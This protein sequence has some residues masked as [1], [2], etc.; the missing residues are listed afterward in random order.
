MTENKNFKKIIFWI[1]FVCFLLVEATLY[2]L[3][4]TKAEYQMPFDVR[5]A[6]IIGDLIFTAVLFLR[7]GRTAEKILLLLAMVFTAVADFFLVIRWEQEEYLI[8]VLVFLAAQLLHF[9]RLSAARASWKG[10]FISLFVRFLLTGAALIIVKGLD[11]WEPLNCFA[12]A[13]FTELLMNVVDA[14][15]LT[16]REKRFILAFI[17]FF[18]FVCCDITVGLNLI[19]GDLG[20]PERAADF[21]AYLTWIFYLPSQV[22][23]VTATL[24]ALKRPQEETGEVVPG[25]GFE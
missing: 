6:A 16:F 1:L 9:A 14:G 8:A 21:I 24:P 18:L 17:G 4:I 15:I 12:V 23:I 11:L 7:K 10:I 20:I 2:V 5:Y 19:G 25:K 13:Y 22:L 3:I